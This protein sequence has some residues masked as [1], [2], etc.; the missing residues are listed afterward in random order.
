MPLKSGHVECRDVELTFALLSTAAISM[1]LLP[2]EPGGTISDAPHS[3]RSF[4]QS[5]REPAAAAVPLTAVLPTTAAPVAAVLPTTTVP[6]TAVLPVTVTAVAVP[7][8]TSSDGP[9]IG[10]D[11]NQHRGD[12]KVLQQVRDA[13][14]AGAPGVL[15]PAR[16]PAPMRGEEFSYPRSS[17]ACVT[18][19]GASACGA[20]WLRSGGCARG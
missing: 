10:S 7:A 1:T 18:G 13:L 8:A 3:T 15:T 20:P 12:Q 5:S 9:G 4:R 16:T 2:V 11:R 17:A 6:L 19:S 14:P